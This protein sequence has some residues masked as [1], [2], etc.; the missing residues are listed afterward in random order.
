MFEAPKSATFP[1]P[2]ALVVLA[3]AVPD[4]NPILILNVVELVVPAVMWWMRTTFLCRPVVPAPD[5]PNSDTLK[6][7]AVLS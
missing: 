4:G 3:R 2:E 1:V 5:D 7:F 6:A